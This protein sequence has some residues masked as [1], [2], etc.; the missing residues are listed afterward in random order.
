MRG[1]IFNCKIVY[2]KRRKGEHYEM[3]QQEI[4]EE[5]KARESYEKRRDDRRDGDSRS[6]Q[7]GFLTSSNTT[8]D[9]TNV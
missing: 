3:T 1:V 7:V 2:R 6:R 9:Q 8:L 4:Q 5:L